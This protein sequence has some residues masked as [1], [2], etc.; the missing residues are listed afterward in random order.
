VVRRRLRRQVEVTPRASTTM[1]VSI[2]TRLANRK[3]TSRPG[4][5]RRR[6]KGG[7]GRKGG[8]EGPHYYQISNLVGTL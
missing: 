4:R 5:G 3:A 7:R 1:M 6:E 8:R 2:G